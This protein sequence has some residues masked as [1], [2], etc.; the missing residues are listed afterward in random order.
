MKMS[1]TVQICTSV[2]ISE[3]PNKENAFNGYKVSPGLLKV[4]QLL[5]CLSI[6]KDIP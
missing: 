5:L 6:I 4:P 2:Q 1:E 3:Y